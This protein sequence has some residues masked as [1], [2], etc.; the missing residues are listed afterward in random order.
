MA[1]KKRKNTNLW[2]LCHLLSDEA[3]R[4]K[5]RGKDEDMPKRLEIISNWLLLCLTGDDNSFLFKH[6]MK[7][8]YAKEIKEGKMDLDEI[9]EIAERNAEIL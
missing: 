6:E 3:K 4:A 7:A 5:T 1:I 2:V 8:L 9:F